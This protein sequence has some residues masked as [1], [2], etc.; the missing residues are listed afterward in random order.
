[1]KKLTKSEWGH[2]MEKLSFNLQTAL[3]QIFNKYRFFTMFF[4]VTVLLSALL[5]SVFIYGWIN[6]STCHYTLTLKTDERDTAATCYRGKAVIIHT[7]VNDQGEEQSKWKVE[8]RYLRVGAQMVFV[9]Y[10]RQAIIQNKKSD[11][12]DQFN[13]LSSGLTFLFYHTKRVGDKLYIFQKFPEYN[14]L[15]AKVSGK[16][17][18]WD[19]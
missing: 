12:N 3:S 14:I 9:V 11:A 19:Q 16:L 5:A 18:M 8:A 4:A 1:M 6:G 7:K 13:R 17:D 10:Q 15:Q 2:H